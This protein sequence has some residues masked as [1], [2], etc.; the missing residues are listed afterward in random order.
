MLQGVS[1]A[2]GGSQDGG[3]QAEIRL[4]SSDRDQCLINRAT[5]LLLVA[6]PEEIADQPGEFAPGMLV[7]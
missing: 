4:Y 6:I 2:Q 7:A 5:V 3:H 1:K